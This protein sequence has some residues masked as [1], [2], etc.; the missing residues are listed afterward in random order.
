MD[1][2]RPSGTAP[3]DAG[4]GSPKRAYRY[5][6]EGSTGYLVRQAHNALQRLLEQSIAPHGVLR[7]QWY[8]LRV[9][10]EE[11]GLTQRELSA[12]VGTKEPTTIVALRSMEAAGLVTRRRSE[13]D[14]RKIHVDLTPKA[15]AL[16]DTL[17][18]LARGVSETATGGLTP[19]ETETLHKLLRKVG[20]TLNEHPSNS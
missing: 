20:A 10:W 8:F 5:P 19:E 13:T 2:A 18:P 6:P 17:L 4:S 16:R 14:R 12:R 15:R 3:S 9:L 11:E 1:K 7:G